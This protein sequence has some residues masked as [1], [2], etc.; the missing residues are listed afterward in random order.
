MPSAT[1]SFFHIRK[2]GGPQATSGHLLLLDLLVN[3]M[4]GGQ[5]LA[6]VL[7]GDAQLQHQHH[8]MVGQVADLVDGLGLVLGLAGD[9][10]LGG[11]LAH[12]LQNLVQALLE[13]VRGVGPLLGVGLAAGQHL[14]Q[15]VQGEGVVLLAL[16]QGVVEAGLRAGMAGRAVLVDPHHQ[17]VVVAVGGDVDDVLGTA[18]AENPELTVHLLHIYGQDHAL[19]GN[20]VLFLLTV[21][22]FVV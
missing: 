3:D 15:G 6:D 13:E 22:L 17:G 2:P 12:L 14:H 4:A 9:D 5:L 7:Q 11:L 1:G 16:P 21:D 19:Y 8:D 10:D 18:P 20:N